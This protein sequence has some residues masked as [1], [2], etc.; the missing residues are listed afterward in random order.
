MKMTP[1]H[2][3]SLL[4]FCLCLQ[5]ALIAQVQDSLLRERKYHIANTRVKASLREV[6]LNLTP[7]VKWLPWLSIGAGYRFESKFTK[8]MD[9]LFGEQALLGGSLNGPFVMAGF[10]SKNWRT[11]RMT[12]YS[13]HIGYKRLDA[14][15]IDY[16]EHGCF[17]LGAS[18]QSPYKLYDATANEVFFKFLLDFQ[19]RKQLASLYAGFGGAFRQVRKAF[20][21][22][23][24]LDEYYPDDDVEKLLY[25]IPLCDMGLRINFIVL[26]ARH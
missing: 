11:F 23:G 19:S 22:S 8:K 6:G 4:S 3:L 5:T 13:A 18:S 1:I 12:N 10:D 16:V 24:T 2:F 17:G 20:V 25:F 26:K 14:G 7:F 15:R 21:E 9:C